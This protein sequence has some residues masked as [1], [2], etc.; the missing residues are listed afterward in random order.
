MS[1]LVSLHCYWWKNILTA[2][3]GSF[4]SQDAV[5]V[6]CRKD[7]IHCLAMFALRYLTDVECQFLQYQGEINI[8]ER[9]SYREKESC[10]SQ[11]VLNSYR[12]TVTQQNGRVGGGRAGYYWHIACKWWVFV[13]PPSSQRFW[14]GFALPRLNLVGPWPGPIVYALVTTVGGTTYTMVRL[15][16]WAWLSM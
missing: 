10:Q 7:L 8:Q 16:E 13:R 12:T 4:W 15:Q 11:Y 5:I 2:C 14:P 6:Q 9:S 1:K 3:L